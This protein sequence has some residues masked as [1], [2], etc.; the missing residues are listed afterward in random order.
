MWGHFS[1]DEGGQVFF[2]FCFFVQIFFL[3]GSIF[4]GGRRALSEFVEFEEFLGLCS[5]LFVLFCFVLFVCLFVCLCE[6][7]CV[8]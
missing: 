4:F 6:C 1:L 5:S 3:G 8:F 7:L 2:L